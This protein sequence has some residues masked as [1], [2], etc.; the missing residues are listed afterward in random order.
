MN[1]QDK[2]KFLPVTAEDMEKELGANSRKNGGCIPT[3]Q[4]KK[5]KHIVSKP[6]TDIW[7]T[8]CVKNGLYPGRLKL[9]DI[10]PVFKALESSFKKNYRPISVLPII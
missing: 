9:S 8:E 3:K 7:N 10:T 6:L 1:I 4:L 2:F 5:M